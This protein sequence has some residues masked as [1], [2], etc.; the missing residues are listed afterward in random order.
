MEKGAVK[1]P[2]STWGLLSSTGKREIISVSRTLNDSKKILCVAGV[3]NPKACATTGEDGG[4]QTFRTHLL[5]AL[6]KKPF[7]VT[8]S[9][10][11]LF[12]STEMSIVTEV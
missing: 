12:R 1:L 2:Q 6:R 9:A 10:D 5:P 11:P 7:K 4:D 8:V 3:Q